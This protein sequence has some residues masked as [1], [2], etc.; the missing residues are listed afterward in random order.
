MQPIQG[1]WFAAL[2]DEKLR[3]AQTELRRSGIIPGDYYV[4]VF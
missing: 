2:N 3:E 1:R 4:K